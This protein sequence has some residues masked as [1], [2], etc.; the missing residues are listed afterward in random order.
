[1]QLACI[2]LLT[3]KVLAYG[4]MHVRRRIHARIHVSPRDYASSY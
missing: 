4:Y 2:L 1:M 3:A